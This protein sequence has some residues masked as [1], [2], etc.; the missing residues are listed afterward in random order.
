MTAHRRSVLHAAAIGAALYAMSAGPLLG[1]NAAN[2][3]HC[4]IFSPHA[5][6]IL[7]ACAGPFPGL[8]RT[9]TIS[10]VGSAPNLVREIRLALDEEPRPFQSISVDARPVVDI[11][12]VGILL[13]DMNFDGYSDLALMQSLSAGYRYFLY[14]AGTGR[15]AASAELDKVAWPEFDAERRTVKSYWQ[16]EDGTFGHDVYSWNDGRLLVLETR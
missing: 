2:D 16:R 7:A 5:T 12:T 3:L 8:D 4:E 15:F 11:E 14:N 6:G 10:L 1:A 13:M 9:I